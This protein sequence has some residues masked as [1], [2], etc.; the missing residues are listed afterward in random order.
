MLRRIM[1]ESRI[2]PGLDDDLHGTQHA[3]FKENLQHRV[4]MHQS[5]ILDPGPYAWWTRAGLYAGGVTGTSWLGPAEDATPIG[6]RFKN[7]TKIRNHRYC[8]IQ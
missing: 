3:N 4:Q 2:A 7:A 5:S 1:L 8:T 6:R